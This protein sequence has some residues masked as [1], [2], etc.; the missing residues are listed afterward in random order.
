M[1]KPLTFILDS[2]TATNKQSLLLDGKNVKIC[3]KNAA[4]DGGF[5]LMVAF[6]VHTAFRFQLQIFSFILTSLLFAK[7]L[8]QSKICQLRITNCIEARFTRNQINKSRCCQ[9]SLLRFNYRTFS[10]KQLAFIL[11]YHKINTSVVDGSPKPILCNNF[12]LS[13]HSSSPI[14]LCR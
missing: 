9:R 14:A 12:P 7:N 4:L 11:S 6:D 3:V 1:G 13:F 8:N 2:S 10:Y 5:A